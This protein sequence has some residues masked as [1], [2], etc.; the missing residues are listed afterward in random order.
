MPTT[1]RQRFKL[2]RKRRLRVYTKWFAANHFTQRDK[3]ATQS[4]RKKGVPAGRG[5]PFFTSQ[6]R[7][8]SNYPRHKINVPP[9]SA[10]LTA[11]TGR[12]S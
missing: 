6:S 4:K 5:C 10:K 2:N 8:V 11:S 9:Q 3:S 7:R 1:S 12:L